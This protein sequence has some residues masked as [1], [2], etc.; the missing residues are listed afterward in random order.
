MSEITLES[1][2]SFKN[3][4]KSEHGL[5]FSPT[6]R[7][8]AVKGGKLLVE[9]G[10]VP[11]PKKVPLPQSALTFYFGFRDALEQIKAQYEAAEKNRMKLVKV[12]VKFD[13]G[14]LVMTNQAHDSLGSTRLLNLRRIQKDLRQ[15]V[16]DMVNEFVHVEAKDKG[17][18]NP[19]IFTRIEDLGFRPDLMVAAIRASKQFSNIKAI[20]WSAPNDTP[21]GLQVV[22]ILSNEVNEIE[23]RGLP[24]PEPFQVVLPSL[25]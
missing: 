21:K 17:E 25:K 23:L 5:A 2:V 13:I 18:S 3:S 12:N 4:P 6:P 20:C 19:Q 1:F 24:T 22:S 14:Q 7:S 9:L 16:I 8:V 10:D 15:Q 11:L